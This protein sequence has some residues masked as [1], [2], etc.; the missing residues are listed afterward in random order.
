[1]KTTRTSQFLLRSL[2]LAIAA[3]LAVGAGACGRKSGG[4]GKS[5]GAAGDPVQGDWLIMHS[6]SDPEDLNYLTSTDAGAQEIHNMMYETLTSVDWET[7]KTIPVL[8]DSL[9]VMSEDRMS[10]EISIRKDARFADGKPVTADDFIF[11]LK[12]LKNPYVVNAAPTRGYYARVDRAERI[13]NDPLRL[14]VIMSEPYYLGDQWVGGLVALPKHIW[15]PKGITD[16][17]SFDEL[18]QNDPNKNPAIKEFSDWFQDPE[19]GR[20]KAFL[21][22]SGPYV[23]SEWI[24][25]DRVVLMRNDNYWKKNDPKYGRAYPDRLVWKTVNDMNAALASLKSGTI[26]FMPNIEKLQYKNVRN[27]LGQFNLDSA[28]YPYPS[29][30]Y[31]GY[32]EDRPIFKDKLVRQAL[33]HAINREAIIKSIYFNYA[34]PVQ[35]PILSRRPESDTTLPIIPFDLAK[36][37]SLLAQAGWNDTDG[38]GVL[39]KVINGRKT[40]FKFQILLNSGNERRKSMGLIFVQ[41]LKKIGV[42]ASTQSIDWALFL[43]RTRDGDYDAYI[44]GWAA[45]VTEG[46]MYQIWHSASAARGGSN[47]VRFKNARVDELIEQIRSE[48]DFEKRKVHYQEI[49]KIIHEEQPYNFLVA[50]R[51]TGAYNNRFENVAFYDPRPSYVP[52]WWWVPKTAQKYTQGN[53]ATAM[54]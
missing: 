43:D 24:R 52:A 51:M 7:I 9:P 2:M 26:D 48:F 12:A 15:D 5:D 8:A 1:M 40:P 22:G 32:N 17:I 3:L 11:F 31:V 37:K 39:D 23:F 34:R 6:L 21:I 33:A 30:T 46:D 27:N 38:D 42:D 16:K 14:R 44:G 4:G 36:A 45:G 54:R 25:N 18:N 28:V 49:Q 29:Y 47:Y 19:K 53:K 35:S 50:E 20:D 41:D 10:Y 13:D